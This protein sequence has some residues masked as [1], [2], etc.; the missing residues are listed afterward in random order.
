MK[1]LLY[2]PVIVCAC[3][4]GGDSRWRQGCV[5]G[6]RR[7]CFPLYAS[8]A[9]SQSWTRSTWIWVTTS[10]KMFSLAAL[11]DSPLLLLAALSNR[12]DSIRVPDRPDC[13]AHASQVF[14]PELAACTNS[15]SSHACLQVA[16]C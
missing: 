14:N 9:W 5:S 12:T 8:V 2:M 1:T 7:S 15:G 13:A 3:A 11:K 4:P 6:A 16:I 10:D